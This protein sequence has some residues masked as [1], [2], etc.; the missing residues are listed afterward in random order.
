MSS[1]LSV[2]V[3]G[4]DGSYPGPGGAC[5]GYLVRTRTTSLWLDA[6]PGTLA[7]LQRHVPLE[8]LDAVVVTHEHI[9]HWSDLE[10]LAVAVRWVVPRPPVPLHCEADLVSSMRAGGTDVFD[11]LPAGPGEVTTVGDMA[12]TFSRT[13]HPVDTLAVRIDA[14]GRSLGYSADSGPAWDLSA[15]GPGIDLALCE[16]TFLSDREG[17]LSHMSARQAGATARAA[18]VGRLVVTHLWPRT[19]RAAARAEAEKA[20]AGP[21]AVAF[22]GARYEV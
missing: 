16:A 21:V 3:L 6:G 15:L 2:T 7:N 22:A 12:L 8:E 10:H 18:G 19:D 5:S 20:F 17:S 13:D 1:G 11:W 9:D 14:A 4:A